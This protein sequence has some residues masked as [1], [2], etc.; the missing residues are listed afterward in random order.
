[1]LAT[2]LLLAEPDE[3]IHIE[4]CADAVVER[5]IAIA[6][7]PCVKVSKPIAILPAPTLCV[8][9]LASAPIVTVLAPTVPVVAPALYPKL[10][11]LVPCIAAPAPPVRH[12]SPG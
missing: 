4:S 8:P 6:L 2:V 1:M 3:L 10:T 5:P 11:P 9:L 7:V 12:F